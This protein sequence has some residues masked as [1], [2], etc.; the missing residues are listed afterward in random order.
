MAAILCV[1]HLSCNNVEIS[2]LRKFFIPIYSKNE[3][4][5]IPIEVKLGFY[6]LGFKMIFAGL[7]LRRSNRF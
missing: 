3:N 7:G 5:F 2:I 1:F 4:V 6:L